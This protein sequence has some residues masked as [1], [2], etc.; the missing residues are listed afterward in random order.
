MKTMS[1]FKVTL[2]KYTL[3]VFRTRPSGYLNDS[4]NKFVFNWDIIITRKVKSINE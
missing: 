1:L 3:W 2:W 4:T